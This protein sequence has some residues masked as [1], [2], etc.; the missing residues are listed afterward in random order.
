MAR[1]NRAQRLTAFD[2]DRDFLRTA[3]VE[4]EQPLPEW[5]HSETE[6]DSPV[7]DGQ[8]SEQCRIAHYDPQRVVVETELTRPGLLVLSDAWFP[9]W[10]AVVT[11]RGSSRE[12]PIYRTNRVL[13]GVWLPAGT[14]EVEFRYQPASFGR[15]AMISGCSWSLLAI[16]GLVVFIRRGP[17]LAGVRECSPND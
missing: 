10:R 8:P 1:G 13:R 14:C 12:A 3:V 16:V 7:S 17:R 15:G 9:G 6:K 4:T 2:G 11:T 5:S